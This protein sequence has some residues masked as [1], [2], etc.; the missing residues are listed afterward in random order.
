MFPKGNMYN[1]VLLCPRMNTQFQYIIKKIDFRCLVIDF[2]I[3]ILL[4]I[5]GA[6]KRGHVFLCLALGHKQ[7]INETQYTPI[8]VQSEITV[9]SHVK[10]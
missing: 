4:P 2:L 9:S 8:N 1:V 7:H 5:S 6:T 10:I 3:Q